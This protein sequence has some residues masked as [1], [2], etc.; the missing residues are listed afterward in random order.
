MQSPRESFEEARGGADHLS[1]TTYSPFN[2]PDLSQSNSRPGTATQ[3]ST[4]HHTYQSPSTLEAGQKGFTQNDVL[5]HFSFAPATTTT[6]V[7]TTTT[8]TTTFPPL[9]MKGPRHIQDPDSK[10]YPLASTPTPPTLKKF[11]FDVGGRPTIFQEAD[12]A[13]ESYKSVS[14]TYPTSV[15]EIN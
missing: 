14:C 13:A 10:E 1:S 11:C 5:A 12:H 7:T 9:V 4:D 8:T 2:S 6:V 15:G 3:M